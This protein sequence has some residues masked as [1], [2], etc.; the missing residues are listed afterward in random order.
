[1]GIKGL[2]IVSLFL[3]FSDQDPP[4]VSRP[5]APESRAKLAPVEEPYRTAIDRRDL[6]QQFDPPSPLEGIYELRS[7]VRP[8]QAQVSGTRGYLLIGRHYMSL[9]IRGRGD[10]PQVP[11]LQATFRRYTIL[12][13]RLQMSTVI[14]HRNE[15]GGDILIEEEGLTEVRRYSLIGSILR[16]FQG[17]GSFMEFVRVE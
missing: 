8:G 1:M 7:I 12:G 15:P 3:L 11:H 14:G 5:S 13:D 16:I 4:A 2:A 17:P 9:H 6:I 10:T